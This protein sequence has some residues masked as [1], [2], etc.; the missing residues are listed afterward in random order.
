VQRVVYISSPRHAHTI[1]H[2][3]DDTAM[4]EVHIIGN[5]LGASAFPQPELTCKWA[6]VTSEDWR[7][8]EG[9]VSGQ[10]QVDVPLVCLSEVPL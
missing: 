3:N 5:I 6:L 9:D 2:P 8:V 10:T 1:T 4:A 7:V